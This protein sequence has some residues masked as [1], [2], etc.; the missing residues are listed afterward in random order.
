MLLCIVVDYI[1]AFPTTVTLPD[2]SVTV[3]TVTTTS[4]LPVVTVE[5]GRGRSRSDKIAIGVGLGIGIPSL[6]L[7]VIGIMLN[8]PKRGHQAMQNHAANV[9]VGAL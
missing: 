6:I 2:G 1:T 4:Q 7:M 8:S 5:G 9:A 3:S